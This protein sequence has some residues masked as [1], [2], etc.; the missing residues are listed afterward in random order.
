MP[1]LV[2]Q[3]YATFLLFLPCY[4]LPVAGGEKIPFL[5]KNSLRK[6]Q[7][8]ALLQ[9]PPP[10]SRTACGKGAG[11]AAAALGLFAVQLGCLVGLVST[12][13]GM[14]RRNRIAPKGMRSCGFLS[15]RCQTSEHSVRP[16]GGCP[17]ATP[18]ADLR[19]P[20]PA[21]AWRPPTLLLAGGGSETHGYLPA[22]TWT[23]PTRFTPRHQPAI[24]WWFCIPAALGWTGTSSS[25]AGQMPAR[26]Q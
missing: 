3:A 17:N 2:L 5:K 10:P 20:H 19:G 4:G 18:P 9:S 8:L 26:L 12:E 11:T 16:R 15:P 24:R 14:R 7:L 22:G 25:R 23:K 6:P 13:K 21:R 1:A